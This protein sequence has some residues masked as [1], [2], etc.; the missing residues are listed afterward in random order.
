[1]NEILDDAE[2]RNLVISMLRA[3]KARD[4]Q[5][6]IGASD[7]SN[8]CD[9]CLANRLLGRIIP[10]P[11]ADSLWLGAEMGTALHG[12]LQGRHDELHDSPMF[13]QLHGSHAEEH[14]FFG[15][16]NGYGDVH[17]DSGGTI[18]LSH[19][20]QLEDYKGST[21]KKSCLLQDYLQSIGA[22][23]QGLE[24]WWK[25]QK[26]TKAYEGGYKL[27]LG[28][29]I[30][31]QLSA[32][33]YR[34]ELEGMKH[35]VNGYYGQLNTYGL[36]RARAGR[37]VTRLS[38]VWINRDGHGMFDDPAHPRYEDPN[39]IHDV[40]VLSFDYNEA[41]ALG[42]LARAQRIWDA[43]SAGATPGDFTQAAHCFPCSLEI[44]DA[45]RGHDVVAT[46]NLE[47]AA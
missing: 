22:M 27:N 44:A 1:M 36:A 2:I 13:P 29:G 42:L 41:Y 43:L 25:K 11:R 10:N 45:K 16:I 8:D 7:L 21:R 39:A 14:L 40:W 33:E 19:P 28:S 32:N 24:P 47:M 30:T 15:R 26:D 31:A 38:I 17:G 46:M 23:R 3:P 34:E 35:K 18:D 20:W 4:V 12:H 9:R 5:R 6:G 37:P